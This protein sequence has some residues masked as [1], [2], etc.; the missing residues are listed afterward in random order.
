[1]NQNPSLSPKPLRPP[2]NNSSSLVDMDYNEL[3]STVED[4][5][6]QWANADEEANLLEET[7]KT[8]LAQLTMQQQTGSGGGR[9]MAMNQAE[10]RAMAEPSY[11]EHI[12]NMV[13]KRAVANRL[14]VRYESGKV[15]IDLLRSL[16]ANERAA[17]QMSGLR[18]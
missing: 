13:K 14:K 18:T 4:L 6:T 17:M 5:G 7:K 8:L 3:V 16:L 12:E 11:K 1:M 10:T 9:P 15:K 2:R